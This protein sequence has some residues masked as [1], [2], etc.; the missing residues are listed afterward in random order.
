MRA[1]GIISDKSIIECCLLDLEKYNSYIELFIPSIH[2][3]GRLFTQTCAI[4]YIATFTK[5][6]TVSHV[7]EILTNYFLPHI[8]DTNFNEKA[9]FVGY[10]VKELLKVLN[11][12]YF[13]YLS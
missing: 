8:G 2:D 10:M 13:F 12:I 6:K 5:G 9:F 11:H 1:L 7:L 4:K 3:A